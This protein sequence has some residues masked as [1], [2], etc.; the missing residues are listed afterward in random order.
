MPGCCE[1]YAFTSVVVVVGL[2][3]VTVDRNAPCNTISRQLARTH[4]LNEEKGFVHG[5]CVTVA[6]T[7]WC[8]VSGSA[9]C[10]TDPCRPA[11]M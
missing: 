7:G 11:V 1:V 4:R 9:S 8:W 10:S 2:K 6:G 5:I 3:T